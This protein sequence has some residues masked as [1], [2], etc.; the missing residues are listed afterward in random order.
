VV[1]EVAEMGAAYAKVRVITS[2]DFALS[3]VSNTSQLN[4]IARGT[5][6]GRMTLGYIAA[7]APLK[8]QEK[9]FTSGLSP[10]R[11]GRPRPR[12]LLLGKVAKIQTQSDLSTLQVS[13]QPSVQVGRIRAVLVL[14]E[15]AG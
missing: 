10:T 7:D 3:A 15:K 12:G 14:T 4:G 5:G 2:P 8:L 11:D 1:G 9:L 13:V 6:S